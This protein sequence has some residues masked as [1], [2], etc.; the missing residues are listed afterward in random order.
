[1][2]HGELYRPITGRAGVLSPRLDP[3]NYA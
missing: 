3:L 2:S 1:M